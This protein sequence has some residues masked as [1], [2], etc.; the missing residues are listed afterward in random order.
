MHNICKRTLDCSGIVT[1]DQSSFH[2]ILEEIFV[3]SFML[4][5]NSWN[6]NAMHMWYRHWILLR[7]KYK[8]KNH[9]PLWE[10][11]LFSII[12]PSERNTG[13]FLNCLWMRITIIA[14]SS[15]F[16]VSQSTKIK[17][18][19]YPQVSSTFCLWLK[20]DWYPEHLRRL[21]KECKYCSML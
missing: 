16:E 13:G 15:C 8:K 1:F 10:L 17:H 12:F 6:L 20:W 18:K 2:R 14:H 11:F 4:M 21:I 7:K 3:K 5:S 19:T 9:C